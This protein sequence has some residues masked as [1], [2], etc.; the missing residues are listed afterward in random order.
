[1]STFGNQAL[2]TTK[3]L[4]LIRHGQAEHNLGL[5]GWENIL[6]PELTSTGVQQASNLSKKVDQLKIDV[7]FVSPLRRTL[8][9][10]L[11]I[12]EQLN[13][14][15]VATDLL[16]EHVSLKRC[17]SRLPISKTKQQYSTVDFSLVE[18]DEDEEVKN[19]TTAESENELSQR[20]KNFLHFIQQRSEENIAVVAHHG[21][22]RS[23][24]SLMKEIPNSNANNYEGIDFYNCEHRIVCLNPDQAQQN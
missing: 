15:L 6:D 24:F 13:R 8:H 12:F 14:P 18:I 22:L 9:T 7:I 4:H 21:F 2:Y 10:A 23:F 1:M 5:L 11:T 16:R 20:A 19:R 3:T 17:D